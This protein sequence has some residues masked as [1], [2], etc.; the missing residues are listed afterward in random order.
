MKPKRPIENVLTVAEFA[1]LLRVGHQTAAKYLASGKLGDDAFK[2]P[3][4]H[5]R[6]REQAVRR[7]L[8]PGAFR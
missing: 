6:V 7:M 4:G 2:T 3:G 1:T 5:W 8:D